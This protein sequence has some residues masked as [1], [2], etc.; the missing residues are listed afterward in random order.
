[1]ANWNTNFLLFLL[2][3]IQKL[4]IRLRLLSP[5]IFIVINNVVYIAEVKKYHCKECDK[6]LSTRWSYTMHMRRHSGESEFTYVCDLCGQGF[7]YS[8]YF[9]ESAS[10]M[11]FFYSLYEI[12]SLAAIKTR[13]PFD[14]YLV[15]VSKFEI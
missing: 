15:S 6:G 9:S 10:A 5:S 8:S 2:Y 11:T 4:S 13:L 1:M 14:P 3:I 12:L 7:L